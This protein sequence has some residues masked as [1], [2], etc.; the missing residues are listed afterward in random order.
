MLIGKPKYQKL[1]VQLF[2]GVSS[3][4]EPH[5]TEVLK[6]PNR[7]KIIGGGA[8]TIYQGDG[9]YLTASYPGSCLKTWVV[10]AKDHEVSCP[11]TIEAFA[12][13]I[14]DPDDDWDVVLVTANSGAPIPHPTAQVSV[15]AGYVMTG[16]G[17]FVDWK[18]AGNLLTASYPSAVNTWTV[19][20]KDH[21]VS[22]PATI[23][24]YAIGIKPTKAGE[25]LP[26]SIIVNASSAKVQH[27]EAVAELGKEWIMTC[28][29]A[30]DAWTGNGN[31]LTGSYPLTPYS[32]KATGKDAQVADPAILTAYA[33]GLKLA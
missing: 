25:P 27:P 6:V 11:A 13:A 28:G 29:G 3:P 18:G 24:A 5:P 4:A 9:N 20:S 31:L 33:I 21:N 30:K 15:P 14:D 19:A 22:S 17:A 1:S 10:A 12:L 8:R 2:Y 7:Y 23:T 26:S 32:W 16:G